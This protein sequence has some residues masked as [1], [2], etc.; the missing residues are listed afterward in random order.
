MTLVRHHGGWTIV[1]T[2]II[3]LMLSILP[4]PVWAEFY[5][6]AWPVLVLIYWCMALPQRVGVGIGWLTGLM[7]DV[8]KGALLGQHALALAV[9]CYLTLN[10]HQRIRVFPLWQ[11]ALTIMVLLALYQ[12]LILWFDGIT[13][14]QTHKG[15]V[16]WMPT[17][18]G[19]LLWP[20]IFV[21]LRDLR[22]RFKVS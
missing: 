20:W 18:I 17:L 2:I 9:V 13:A 21:V 14:G 22:R 1:L 15:W 19:T 4:L 16:Y 7:L 8:L 10:L 11:Q 12:L 5:R 3:A 6:P